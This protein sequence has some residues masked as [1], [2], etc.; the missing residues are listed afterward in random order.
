MS[1]AAGRNWILVS[2][3]S[4]I[5]GH[6]EDAELWLTIFAGAGPIVARTYSTT[7]GT[8][9]QIDADALVAGAGYT[10]RPNEILWYTL[11]SRCPDY[12]CNELHVSPT[13]FVGGDHSF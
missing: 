2:H 12:L 3:L 6:R 9:V 7:S 1:R 5:R 8:A 4:K 11:E 13:G 10:P